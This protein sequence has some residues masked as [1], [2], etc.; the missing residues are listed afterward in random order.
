[1]VTEVAGTD[2]NL[3][4]EG[5]CWRREGQINQGGGEDGKSLS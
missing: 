3:D 4:L 2:E 1:M 5:R